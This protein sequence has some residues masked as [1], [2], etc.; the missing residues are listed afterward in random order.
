MVSFANRL[1]WVCLNSVASVLVQSDVQE[2]QQD[3]PVPGTIM[4]KGFTQRP[5][6]E[7]T[8]RPQNLNWPP[9]KHGYGVLV[10]KFRITNLAFTQW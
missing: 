9:S 1:V 7:I 5:K 10:L 8:L 4:I 6:S 2:R 3:Y